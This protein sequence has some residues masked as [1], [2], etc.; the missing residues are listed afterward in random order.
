MK[1]HADALA[2]DTEV[3]DEPTRPPAKRRSETADP[4]KRSRTGKRRRTVART[5]APL[6]AI[7]GLDLFSLP[8][9]IVLCVLS[10]CAAVD[11]ARVG[12]T[13]RW[14]AAVVAD[15]VSMAALYRR[16]V[17]PHCAN[18]LCMGRFGDAVDDDYFAAGDPA[19]LNVVRLV[20]CAL[21]EYDLDD[22]RDRHGEDGGGVRGQGGH[23]ND[24]D[25]DDGT[26]FQ[27]DDPDALGWCDGEGQCDG[28][29]PERDS[30]A[31]GANGQNG[32]TDDTND[33]D[34][35]NDT[36]NSKCGEMGEEHSGFDRAVCD[37]RE[38]GGAP[39]DTATVD[40]PH[41]S[42]GDGR[43]QR[44]A[45]ARRLAL[46][47]AVVSGSAHGLPTCIVPAE[48]LRRADPRTLGGR[49]AGATE[50]SVAIDEPLWCCRHMP[51]SLVTAIGPLRAL[52]MAD[53]LADATPAPPP[54]D[55][56]TPARAR[57]GGGGKRRNGARATKTIRR[58]SAGHASTLAWGFWR[59]GRLVGPGLVVRASCRIDVGARAE[60]RWALAWEDDG[61]RSD[62]R[63]RPAAGAPFVE[64]VWRVVGARAAGALVCRD[65][66]G[67]LGAVMTST[68]DAGAIVDALVGPGTR[69]ALSTTATGVVGPGRIV[70][71]DETCAWETVTGLVGI[72][73]SDACLWYPAATGRARATVRV[74]RA[75][76]VA[77]T[78]AAVYRG[79]VDDSGE[80][81][82]G[83]GAV[84][85]LDVGHEGARETVVYEGGWFD[86]APHGWG[87]LFDPTT[88]VDG[89]R[90][91]RPLFAGCFSRGAPAQSGTLSPVTG[92]VVEAAGWWAGSDGDG[93]DQ[94][95]RQKG[96]AASVPAPRGAGVV[97]LACGAQLTCDWRAAGS[98]PIVHAVR[99][100][101][102]GLGRAID[103]GDCTL[104]VEALDAPH[105]VDLW[106]EAIEGE[107]LRR[108]DAVRQMGHAVGRPIE[109]TSARWLARVL[110]TSSLRF[111]VR[112]GDSPDA[113]IVVDLAS[114]LLPWPA[115]A[116]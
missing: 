113:V 97:H 81:P 8:V 68:T 33:N 2:K 1:D 67:A 99:H 51:P 4:S 44:N 54:S 88:P 105:D 55:G 6:G 110:T 11:V 41:K 3:V 79:A 75:A 61:S 109:R 28:C 82:N 80:R 85:A 84:Y 60:V 90:D 115:A 22:F 59:D 58:S 93:N 17:G 101:D 26:R 52:A 9:E 62:G 63:F 24:D 83:H 77:G 73:D 31:D 94:G 70:R 102:A 20:D 23:S 112:C 108:I 92:C 45:R 95:G 30:I 25:N 15:P 10:H 78:D 87:R 43:I 53:A 39:D 76:P 71:C 34:N 35:N 36:N 103:G 96:D 100:R 38:P 42:V 104:V 50:I 48:R 7:D 114:M 107:L 111:R 98:A 32:R 66:A 116:T 64:R 106:A 47:Q 49:H 21:A 86:G 37:R 69:V 89:H 40:W 46:K 57:S 13:C 19:P 91:A 74:A 12:L 27:S 18:P 16:A 72:D 5:E 65:R 14:A 29:V 56:S